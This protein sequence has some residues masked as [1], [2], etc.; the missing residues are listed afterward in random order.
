[1]LDCLIINMT[2][3]RLSNEVFRLQ[4]DIVD[5]MY[6]GISTEDLEEWLALYQAERER[7]SYII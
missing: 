2:N 5:S 7:R 6:R 3:E 1:M 4:Q